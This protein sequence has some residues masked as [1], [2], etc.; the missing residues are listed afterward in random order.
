[1]V[2]IVI[3]ALV[4]GFLGLRLYS[5]LGKGTGNEQPWA[6]APEDALR[7]VVSITKNTVRDLAPA[8]SE[9]TA[10]PEVESG[11]RSI[12][13]ADRSFNADEFIEGAASAYRM[14]LEAYWTGDMIAV[15]QFTSPDVHDAFEEAIMLRVADGHVLDNRLINI[16]RAVISSATLVDGTANITVR[17][18]ADIAAVT[19]DRDSN[20]IAGSV[21]DA[22]PTHDSWTFSRVLK[23]SD[24]NWLL[25]DTDEA[26]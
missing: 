9:P 11:L 12:T 3:F 2:G 16:E 1:M 20:V 4:A 18:D 23:T 14:I 15:A 19:R 22:V 21:S 5:V 24:P 7:N 25:T 10:D 17:F 13:V 26:E 8:D 6:R